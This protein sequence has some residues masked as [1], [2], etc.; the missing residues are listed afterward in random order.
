VY[1]KNAEKL[2][3]QAGYFDQDFA[4]FAISFENP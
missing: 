2:S 3:Q 4:N 1:N